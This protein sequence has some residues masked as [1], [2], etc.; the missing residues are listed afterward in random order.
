M[1]ST[2]F[3]L[4][5][6][7]DISL[8]NFPYKLYQ[9][10]PYLSFSLQEL[11]EPFFDDLL[12]RYES[13]G[14]R[15]RS[16][17]APDAVHQ[18]ASGILNESFLGDEPS[19]N[20][21]PRDLLHM[22]NTFSA[23]MPPPLVGIGHSYGGHAIARTALLHPSLFHALILLDPVLEEDEKHPPALPPLQHPVKATA[24][25]RDIWPSLEDAERF[26]RSRPFYKSWDPR[27]LDLH[28]VP[29]ITLFPTHN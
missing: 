21:L 10:T 8:P 23:E 15:I 24:K 4:K 7:L 6:P 12:T 11:Y 29:P 16:I 2:R 19:W 14:L 26:I 18:G 27:V 5:L 17:W 22:I 20:D 3:P 13:S 1:A 28:I 9:L 25:R